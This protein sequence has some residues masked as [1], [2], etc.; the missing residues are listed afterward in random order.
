MPAKPNIDEPQRLPRGRHGL[1]RATVV[2]SQRTRILEGMIVSVA[3]RG[4]P[5]TRVVAAIT[6]AGVSRKT[7]Y[8]LFDDKEHCFLA[9]YDHIVAR[10]LDVTQA[11]FE[12]APESQWTDRIRRGTSALLTWLAGEPEAARVAIV[13]ILAGGPPARVRRAAALRQ[14]TAFVDAG[15]AESTVELPGITS[16]AIVGGI[17]ELLYNEILAGSTA[18]LPSRLPDIVYWITQPFLGPERAALERDRAGGPP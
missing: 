9:S 5:E 3:A 6:A 14:F 15:R 12:S 2:D 13:E 11:G 4:Y 18:D 1:T 16:T 7:F 8:E 17:Y 10:L